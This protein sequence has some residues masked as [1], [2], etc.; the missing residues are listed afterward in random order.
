MTKTTTER[1][2][3]SREF[4]GVSRVLDVSDARVHVEA[5]DV[6]EI[7]I[8][9][10]AHRAAGEVRHTAIPQDVFFTVPIAWS[11]LRVNLGRGPK[12]N[13]EEDSGEE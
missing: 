2:D 3:L 10:E 7:A 1:A 13:A 9:V 8:L 6:I 12:Q 5:R 4:T 11:L